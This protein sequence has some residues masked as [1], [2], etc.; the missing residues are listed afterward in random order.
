LLIKGLKTILIVP[1]YFNKDW[2]EQNIMKTYR[3]ILKKYPIVKPEDG[4]QT[5]YDK[6]S[7]IYFIPNGLSKTK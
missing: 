1:K 6:K 5:L 3:E 7:S 2:F 4:L